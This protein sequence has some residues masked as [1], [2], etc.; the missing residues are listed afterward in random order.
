[1]DLEYKTEKDRLLLTKC[2]AAGK[3]FNLE[4]SGSISLSGRGALALK[5]SIKPSPQFFKTFDKHP[6][7][8]RLFQKAKAAGHIPVSLSGTVQNPLLRFR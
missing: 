6:A 2:T 1:M 4:L 3:D 8:K 5:G 7:M